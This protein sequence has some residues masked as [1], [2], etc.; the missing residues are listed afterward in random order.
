MLAIV[1]TRRKTVREDEMCFWS[2]RMG[3]GMGD[4]RSREQTKHIP[5]IKKR[6]EIEMN[7]L[8]SKRDIISR[9][10]FFFSYARFVLHI[11]KP[12]Y[13]NMT[14]YTDGFPSCVRFELIIGRAWSIRW[15][16]AH[17]RHL[18][19][20]I[21]IL[22]RLGRAAVISRAINDRS[23][24]HVFIFVEKVGDG[25]VFRTISKVNFI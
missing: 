20:L 13:S 16:S 5:T 24:N 21:A 1:D 10:V 9:C 18:S 14:K 4:E 12:W 19:R 8:P 3:M 15:F 11:R 23:R 7:F 2:R 22:C 6:I 25:G 17:L